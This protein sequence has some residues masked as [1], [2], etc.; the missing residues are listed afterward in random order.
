MD[1]AWLGHTS[2]PFGAPPVKAPP[3]Q[4]VSALRV[5]KKLSPETR[6]ALKLTRKFGDSL[7]CV[8]HRSDDKGEYR[9]TTV[10]SRRI[11][12]ILKLTDR[13]TEK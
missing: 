2:N 11:A 12:G 3:K 1:E 7:V 10:D 8:G 6:G 13:I 9:Y 5:T 4:T